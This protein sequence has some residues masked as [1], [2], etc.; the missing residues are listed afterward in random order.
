[1]KYFLDNCLSPDFS[2]ALTILNA[3]LH[4]RPDI[5]HLSE[6]FE[7]NTP[8]EQW[9][10]ELAKDGDWIIIS[11]DPRIARGKAERRAWREARL[12]AFFFAP[13]YA[14]KG[15]WV[16]VEELVRWW[17]KITDKVKT[18]PKGSGYLMPFKGKEFRDLY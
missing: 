14:D 6:L 7:R 17:P 5:L 4:K 16:Q 12:T 8:D 15:Y 10:G 9:I 11:S 3:P 2:K 13:G 1:V 18:A